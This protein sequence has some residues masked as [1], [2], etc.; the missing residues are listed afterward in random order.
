MPAAGVERA[1][2]RRHQG[3]GGAWRMCLP[4]SPMGTRSSCC[5][6]G[7]RPRAPT[8][9]TLPAQHR[10]VCVPGRGPWL[11]GHEKG[12][13]ACTCR[14]QDDTAASCANDCWPPTSACRL[15][16][17]CQTTDREQQEGMLSGLLAQSRQW[18]QAAA[19]AAAAAAAGSTVAQSPEL[20]NA[21]LSYQALLQAPA[22]A[23]SPQ[24]QQSAAGAGA[25]RV[26]AAQQSI[27]QSRGAETTHLSHW[28]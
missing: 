4:A 3:C 9:S 14:A 2:S 20:R 23:A 5:T 19:A 13:D 8:N 28:R 27:A 12:G 25:P 24:Q 7:L 15:P 1:G 17:A 22:A 11:V 26:S 6:W 16:S 10:C 21:R 18:Q